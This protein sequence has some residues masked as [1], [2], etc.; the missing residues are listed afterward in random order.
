MTGTDRQGP[1]RRAVLAREE[2][3]LAAFFDAARA[4][5]PAARVAFL[6]AVLADAA[7]V[8]EARAPAL[9]VAPARQRRAR[10]DRGA[11]LRPLGGW[12][13]A[14]ALAGCAALGFVA[15]ALGTGAGITDRLLAAEAAPL[16][17][18]AESVTLFF[19]LDAVEG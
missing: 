7:A 3:D 14:T 10:S 1:D 17:L 13:G 19:D 16:D 12:I 2:G 4:A 15:G 5:E 18:A 6:D 11:W 8:A 9:P